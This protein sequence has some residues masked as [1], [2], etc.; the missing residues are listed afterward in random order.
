MSSLQLRLSNTEMVPFHMPESAED[1]RELA[2][3]QYVRRTS[4]Y[5]RNVPKPAPEIVLVEPD[6]PR[7]TFIQRHNPAVCYSSPIGPIRPREKVS[8]GQRDVLWLQ[9][10]EQAATLAM[11]KQYVV[12]ATGIAWRHIESPRRCKAL[13]APR[14]LYSMLAKRDTSASFP[15]IGRSLGGRD[16]TTVMHHVRK[17][18]QGLI[19]NCRLISLPE[20]GW[21]V[22]WLESGKQVHELAGT[23][24][25]PEMARNTTLPMPHLHKGDGK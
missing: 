5:V 3:K 13:I 20:I 15:I 9:S 21:H 2:V 8:L 10:D 7:H 4:N 1:V 14:A 22:N 11:V 18:E 24:V 6:T 23:T 19:P 25:R 12:K 17:Y 16:H